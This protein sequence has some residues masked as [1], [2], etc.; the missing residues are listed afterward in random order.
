MQSR[1]G[2]IL[3]T[4]VCA[5]FAR[6]GLDVG[7]KPPHQGGNDRDDILE[8]VHSC[9]SLYCLCTD[10]ILFLYRLSQTQWR[11]SE[12][13]CLLTTR[14]V[15]LARMVRQ[16]SMIFCSKEPRFPRDTSL[17]VHTSSS[18]R[19]H[20]LIASG[21]PPGGIQYDDLSPNG[22]QTVRHGASQLLVLCLTV[23][24]LAHL[25]VCLL[26]NDLLFAYCLLTVSP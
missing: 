12:E 13:S 6:R 25:T 26:F 21:I 23:R 14:G 7:M 10:C 17:T 24:Q 3:P 20:V 22:K 16:S 5:L 11:D 9:L 4:A 18:I 19:C 8:K 15:S 1:Y 2:K